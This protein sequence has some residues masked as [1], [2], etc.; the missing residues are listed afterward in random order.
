MHCLVSVLKIAASKMEPCTGVRVDPDRMRTECF[1]KRERL[2]D[3]KAGCHGWVQGC[4][5]S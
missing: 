1:N 4:Y 3:V 2:P 5:P